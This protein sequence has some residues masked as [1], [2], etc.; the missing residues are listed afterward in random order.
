[1]MGF[2]AGLGTELGGTTTVA[3]LE[4]SVSVEP[5]TII[6]VSVDI[7]ENTLVVEEE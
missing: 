1:M 4:E 3:Y 5:D 2:T 6:D 7:E